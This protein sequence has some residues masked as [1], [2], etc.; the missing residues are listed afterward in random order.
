MSPAARPLEQT[1]RR[2]AAASA[3]LHGV[4][5][6][7]LLV[8]LPRRAAPTDEQPLVIELVRSEAMTPGD[9]PAPQHKQPPPDDGVGP[10]TPK[11]PPPNVN[12]GNGPEQSDPLTVTGDN[13]VP[14]EPDARYRNQPPRYPA[15]AARLGAEGTAQLVIHVSAQGMAMG[16]R[17]VQSSGNRSLD[18]EARRAVALWRFRPAVRDGH[19]VEFDYPVNIRFAIGDHP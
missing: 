19:P 8:S 16:V 10:A 6:A 7:G 12:L 5:L 15:E 2:N 13:V 18:S 11:P 17:V 1:L 14:P 3:L 4:L 9:V